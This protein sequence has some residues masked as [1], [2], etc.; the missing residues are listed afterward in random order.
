MQRRLDE[1][2][3]SRHSIKLSQA[4]SH[5]AARSRYTEPYPSVY[6]SETHGPKRNSGAPLKLIGILLLISGWLL[7]L[8]ALVMLRAFVQ[9][10]G[11]IAAGVGTEAIGLALLIHAHTSRQ[12]RSQ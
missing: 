11:F 6:F 5:N 8:A 1:A 3:A 4:S 2:N 7:T 12:R 9:R 10:A